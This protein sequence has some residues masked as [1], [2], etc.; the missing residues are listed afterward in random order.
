MTK[1]I[2]EMIIEKYGKYGAIYN[3]FEDYY[4]RNYLS[5]IVIRFI[6]KLES[7]NEQYIKDEIRKKENEYLVIP[8]IANAIFLTLYSDFEY[9][10]LNLCKAYK[11]SLNLRL[12]FSDLKGDGI[13]GMMDYLDRVVGIEVKNNKYYQELPH[14][15]KIR[16]ILVHNSGIIE[17]N[18]LPSI[19]YLNIK[20]VDSLGNKIVTLSLEDINRFTSITDNIQNYL[21]KQ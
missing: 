16:N 9:F 14:W 5:F 7:Y 20:T 17:E 8:K 2:P 11:D 10:L 1:T 6:E 21:V 3:S 15:N 12:K 4:H 13:I 19:E 18:A